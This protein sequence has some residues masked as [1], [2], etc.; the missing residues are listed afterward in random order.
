MAG[1]GKLAAAAL[2]LC[3]LLG[4]SQKS[5]A[6]PEAQK[7]T[8]PLPLF[9]LKEEPFLVGEVEVTQALLEELYALL[10]SS[11]DSLGL[12]GF[13]KEHPD[14]LMEHI[15]YLGELFCKGERISLVFPWRDGILEDSLFNRERMAEFVENLQNGQPDC[16][17]RISFGEPLPL[18][19]KGLE[20]PGED[21]ELILHEWKLI[22]ELEHTI[23]SADWEQTSKEWIFRSRDGE[24]CWY[25][26]RYGYEPVKIGEGELSSQEAWDAMEKFCGSLQPEQN[27]V[28]QSTAHSAESKEVYHFVTKTEEGAEEFWAVEKDE[29]CLY[30]IEQVNGNYVLL[31]LPKED[32][33]VG[34][35][36]PK[37]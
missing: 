30:Q 21:G 19:L 7:E 28:S 13:V 4:C 12:A 23:R 33:S 16:I 22:P 36:L 11:P 3:F 8:E 24:I 35:R 5:V 26:P 1:R 14:F 32:F 25:Y 37:D 27:V 29:N 20:Y 18:W 2:L 15:M 6:L 17:A 10:G 34:S 31:A 9:E